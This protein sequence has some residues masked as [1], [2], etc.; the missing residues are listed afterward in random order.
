MEYN[1]DH[2]GWDS[3][4]LEN[5][6]QPRI[7]SRWGNDTTY[8]EA[9]AKML[10]LFH[11]TGRGTLFLYQGQE[12]GMINPPAWTNDELRDLEEIEY[13]NAVKESK[14]D[15]ND[16]LQ[17]IQR[18]G[19]DNA[20]TPMQW[21]AEVNAGFTT[22]TPWIKVNTDYTEWNVTTQLDKEDKSVLGFWKKL[23]SIRKAHPG[24]IRGKFQMIDYENQSVYAYTRTDDAAQYLVVCSFSDKKIDWACS[25]QI[26][27]LLLSNYSVDEIQELGGLKLRPYEG[28]LYIYTGK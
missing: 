8:R 1:Q 20:R 13:Y 21:S 25:V 12:I 24:L 28:R 7:I 23:L 6:D 15:L 9:S 26:G 18:I 14:G 22:G 5:H 19:R 3:L 2:N 16:A 11:A 27:S 4:Y 17:Q 10:A